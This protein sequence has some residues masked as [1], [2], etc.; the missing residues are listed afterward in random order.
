LTCPL[1][2]R[3]R[4]W[5]PHRRQSLCALANQCATPVLSLI[6]LIQIA[7]KTLKGYLPHQKV[8]VLLVFTDLTK[9]DSPRTPTMGFLHAPKGSG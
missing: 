6:C 7:D 1:Q 8:R 4:L 5:H 2:M 3:R 9:D